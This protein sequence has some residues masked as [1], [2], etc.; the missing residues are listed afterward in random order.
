MSSFLFDVSPSDPL[1]LT[2]AAVAVLLLALTASALPARRAA[3][4]DPMR[5]LR[6]D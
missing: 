6:A 3:T 5:A 2:L 1:V 4:I